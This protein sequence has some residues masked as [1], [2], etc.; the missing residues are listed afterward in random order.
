MHGKAARAKI[1]DILRY[2][3]VVGKFKCP[4]QELRVEVLDR[5]TQAR[6]IKG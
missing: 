2:L 3:H 6:Q 4:D 1:Y 5:I